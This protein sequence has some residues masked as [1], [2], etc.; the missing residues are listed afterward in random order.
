MVEKCV[1]QIFHWFL[2]G[3]HRYSVYDKICLP[4]HVFKINLQL[5]TNI[6]K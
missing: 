1:T 6:E 4:S 5:Q 3:R 2:T